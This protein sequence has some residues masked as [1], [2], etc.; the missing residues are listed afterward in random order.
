MTL[1]TPPT[2]RRTPLSSRRPPRALPA[3]RRI[4]LGRL[5]RRRLRTLLE[6]LPSGTITTDASSPASVD[7]FT[8]QTVTTAAFTPPPGSL[9]VAMV[10]AAATFGDAVT[11]SVTDSSGL[12]TWVQVVPAAST[13]N[14]YAG[15]WTAQVPQPGVTVPQRTVQAKGARLPL[16]GRIT[17]GRGIKVPFARDRPSAPRIRQSGRIP[18]VPSRVPSGEADPAGQSRARSMA[19]G[20]AMAPGAPAPRFI[21]RTTDRCFILHGRQSARRHSPCG[22]EASTGVLPPTPPG[23]TPSAPGRSCGAPGARYA[24]RTPGL[25]SVSARHP[26]AISCRRRILVQAGS[27]AASAPPS[28]TRSTDPLPIRSRV[29]SRR[30]SLSSTRELAGLSPILAPLSA[31]RFPSSSRRTRRSGQSCRSSLFSAAGS[32]PAAVRPSRTPLR[33]RRF[34]RQSRRSARGCRSSLFFAVAAPPMPAPPSGTPPPARRSTRRKARP[35]PGSRRPSP[36]A[37][38][39][40][41]PAH[42]YGTPPRVPSSSRRLIPRRRASRRYSPR[43]A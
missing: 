3:W 27:G 25:P 41:M 29:P 21:T 40:P 19:P 15:I 22:G 26:P 38:P 43:D 37:G 6:I 11:M 30:D 2:G 23:I 9:L 7:T 31:I 33:V 1:S 35:A 14:G 24:T 10:T 12:L 16:R 4:R 39:P 34:T 28:R 17:S 13:G 32:A 36:R 42:R 5:L 8:A 18:R 20:S